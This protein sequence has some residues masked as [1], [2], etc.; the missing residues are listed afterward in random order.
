MSDV[1]I[2]HLRHFLPK[3]HVVF[4]LH[5]TLFPMATNG[6]AAMNGKDAKEWAGDGCLIVDLPLPLFRIEAAPLERS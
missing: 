4:V 3:N 5:P 6:S 1:G 2:L